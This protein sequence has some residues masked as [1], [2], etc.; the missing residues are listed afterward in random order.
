M[1]IAW[2]MKMFS[3]KNLKKHGKVSF[4]NLEKTLINLPDAFKVRVLTVFKFSKCSILYKKRI[5]QFPKGSFQKPCYFL[6][7]LKKKSEF[8]NTTPPDEN[9]PESRGP[10]LS[11][12]MGQIWQLVRKNLIFYLSFLQMDFFDKIFSKIN[13]PA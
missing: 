7:I 3:R 1:R 9:P 13:S 4:F 8:E 11:F 6:K 10:L 5:F 12:H 2:I